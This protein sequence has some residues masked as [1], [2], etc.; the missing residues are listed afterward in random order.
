V[1]EPTAPASLPATRT[2]A[3][4]LA[5]AVVEDL[6]ALG[7]SIEN[8]WTYVTDLAAAGRA[9]IRAL[10]GDGAAAFRPAFG[11][12]LAAAADEARSVAD[13]H[14]AIDWLSTFPAIA[15][16]ALA[17][18]AGAGAAPGVAPDSRAGS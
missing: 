13:P 2:E 5:L 11:A 18:D 15:C 14:R 9:A 17:P 4:A 1:T 10:A 7:E 12:A 6:A 8:E 16:L 3:I